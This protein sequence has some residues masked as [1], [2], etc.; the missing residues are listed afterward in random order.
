M[1]VMGKGDICS[2]FNIKDKFFENVDGKMVEN[3]GKE[4]EGTLSTNYS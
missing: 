3:L 4:E 1:V 2:T